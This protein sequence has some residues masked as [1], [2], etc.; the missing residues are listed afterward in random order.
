VGGAV[1]VRVEGPTRRRVLAQA[2]LMAAGTAVAA[3]GLPGSA[4][5][6]GA[7]GGSGKP[8]GTVEFWS[9]SGYPYQGRIGEKLVAEFE[10]ANPGLKIAWTDTPATTKLFQST[11]AGTPPDLG[12]ADRFN[13]KGFACKG[14]P[15]A[16]DEYVKTARYA[17]RGAFWPHLEYETQYRG[18]V[19]AIPHD[20]VLGV[21]CFNRSMFRESGLDPA[22]P[23]STW[24]AAETAIQR[25][26]RRSGGDVERV[27]WVPTRGFGVSWMVMYWQLGGL[28]TSP[29]DKRV[30]YNNE[31]A[32][33]VF[34][35]LLKMNDLQGGEDAITKLYQGTDN[36]NAFR[37]GKAAMVWATYS[38]LRTRFE[39]QTGLDTGISYWPLPPGGKR[40]NYVGG[41]ALIVP[42][43][44]KNPEG[45]FHYLDFLA[46]DD[47]QIRWAEE[48][49]NV[50]AVQSAARS[51]KYQQQRPERKIAVEDLPNAKF[52]V[53]A[54]GGDT[55]LAFQRQVLTDVF[56]RKLTVRDA[57]AESVRLV[58]E[59]LDEAQRGCA[60]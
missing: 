7:G 29:D 47:A 39:T 10:A 34:D 18:K 23:P 12:Y 40:S 24:E 15:R 33:R 42:N 6:G 5:A 56:T 26:T 3:C 38:T 58:Q 27:G 57:V 54:P 30:T 4:P 28:L 50:P 25:L 59:Q 60:V 35:W 13:T 49:N 22:R 52:V 45:A 20:A 11:V 8:Q 55:A 37:D 48:W 53:S 2:G 36:Y 44:A 43:G 51:E 17:K 21:L 31:Q 41:W 9:N 46:T 19:W 32:H 1:G 14:V 16:L